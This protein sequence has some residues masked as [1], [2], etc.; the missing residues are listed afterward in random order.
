MNV[1]RHE[2]ASFC[3]RRGHRYANSRGANR[4]WVGAGHQVAALPRPPVKA[5]GAPVA[6]A[7]YHA[8]MKR[9]LLTGMS[10]TGKSTVIRALAARGYKAIDTDSDEWSAWTNAAGDPDASGSPGEPDWVWREDRIQRLLSTEDAEVLF[11]SGCKSNQGKFYGQFDHIVLLSA[12]THL[13]VERLATR[14]TNPYGKHPDELARVLRHLRTV[15]P[16]LKRGASL[17]VDTS[18]ALDQV[19]ETILAHVRP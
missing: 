13:I 7:L 12:P 5:I 18:V 17:E 15:E 16:L 14:T 8:D 4:G 6:G 9:V 19:I 2:V 11:V 3:G 1:K 10:G